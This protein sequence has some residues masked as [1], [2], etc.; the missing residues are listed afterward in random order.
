MTKYL[1]HATAASLL[2]LCAYGTFLAANWGVANIYYFK[3]NDILEEWNKDRTTLSVDTYKQAQ[4]YIQQS[5]KYHSSHNHYIHTS[6]R[7]LHW[8]VIVGAEN[9]EK[10]DE[11]LKLY[12]QATE[13]RPNWYE[14][15]ADLARLNSF[16]YGYNE[17]TEYYLE[18]ALRT[19]R[20]TGHVMYTAS[21]VYLDNWEYLKPSIKRKYLSVVKDSF[22]KEYRFREQLSLAKE[23]DKLNTVCLLAN[24]NDGY[25]AT[26]QG[27]ISKHCNS[28]S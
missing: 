2:C 7:I 27:L 3:A 22:K 13:T 8:G 5:L 24:V 15:W 19:G 28:E 4:H 10:Y 21:K 12:L 16:L 20:F 25:D 17:E 1:T 14:T 18:Q 26:V 9:D 23:Y 11:V 6:G